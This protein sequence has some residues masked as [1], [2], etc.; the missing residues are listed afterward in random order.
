MKAAVDNENKKSEMLKSFMQV[1]EYIMEF[2]AISCHLEQSDSQHI[3][4]E[5][6]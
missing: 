1:N 4:M 5:L 2:R 6:F 3:T